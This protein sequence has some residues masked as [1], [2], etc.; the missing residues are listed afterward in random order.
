MAQLVNTYTGKIVS[1]IYGEEGT[2]VSDVQ[3]A[4]NLTLVSGTVLGQ[5]SAA[6]ANEVQK[7]DFSGSGDVPTGGTFKIAIA[8][9]TGFGLT[10][11]AALAYN[12][13]NANLKIALDAMLAAAGFTGAAVTLTG[14]ASPVDVNVSFG[15]TYANTGMPLMTADGAALTSSGTATVIVSRTT[16]GVLLGTWAAYNDGHSDGTQVAKAIL[17]YDICTDA[18]GLVTYGQTAPNEFGIKY[19]YAPAYFNGAFKTSELTGLDAAAVADLGRLTSGTVA[20][21]ILAITA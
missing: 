1:P 18:A 17:Q 3:F 13:S 15:G 20:D 16:A 7:I 10:S 8:N 21:G 11:T 2:I 6:S 4:P 12:I 9:Q 19:P 14:G 5:I